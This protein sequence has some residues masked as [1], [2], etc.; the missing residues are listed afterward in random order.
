MWVWN[1]TTYGQ[2]QTIKQ[3]LCQIIIVNTDY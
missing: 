3:N 2:K 1:D